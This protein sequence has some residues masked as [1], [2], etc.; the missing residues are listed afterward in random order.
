MKPTDAQLEE[1]LT[2]RV[3]S[4][5]GG[6]ELSEALASGKKLR[7]KHGVDPTTPDLHLGYSV[8]YHKLREFQDLGHTV[9]FL[10]GSFTA[11]F[12]DPDGKEQ[13]RTLRSAKDV[14]RLAKD[15]LKQAFTVLDPNKTEVRYN[16]EWYDKM[17][18]EELIRLMSHFTYSQ[19]MER[20]M[21][22]KRIKEKLEIRFHEPIYPVLQGYDSVMLKSDVTV[23][24][25]DQTFNEMRG[26]DLQRDFGQE[27]QA[28]I[29]VPLLVGTDGVQ[30]MSQSLGNYIGIAEGPGEQ[31]GKI[32]SI[33]D[34]LIYTY[35]DM[36]TDVDRGTLN[37]IKK[38]LADKN[39]NPRDIK[40]SLAHTIVTM[41]HGGRKADTAQANFVRVFQKGSAPTEMT[42]V[43]LA[44]ATALFDLLVEHKMIASKT[45]GRRL[46]EQGG[47]RIDD[48]QVSDPNLVLEPNTTATIQVGK[49]RFLKISK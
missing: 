27:P 15:Y 6:K 31:Y 22:Q 1:L 40:M 45:E 18:A 30:K 5:I 33:P 29:S 10:I 24:G 7:I 13:T 12:G 34:S 23:I 43:K 44:K 28:I 37:Q 9:V 8:V 47:I 32:M 16:A 17:S 21:F 49:R 11:R 36:A 48:V 41:Y 39:T 14:D 4:V 35:F 42:E 3:D 19:M 46:I 38:Q 2:R 26:R 20:D 25:T